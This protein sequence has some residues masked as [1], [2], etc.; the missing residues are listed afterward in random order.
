MKSRQGISELGGVGS[1]A[2]MASVRTDPVLGSPHATG[3]HAP[4]IGGTDH[5]GASRHYAVRL[6]VVAKG[7]RSCTYHLFPV[8][9][10]PILIWRPWS[11][12]RPNASTRSFAS[13][14][15]RTTSRG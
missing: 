4:H 10:S 1:E 8:S 15:R 6:G 12:R 2:P 9:R 13:F 11:S 3:A 7:G 5:R 14:R